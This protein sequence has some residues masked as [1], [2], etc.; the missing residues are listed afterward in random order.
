MPNTLPINLYNPTKVC[1]RSPAVISYYE[2]RILWGQR[3]ILPF[4]KYRARILS[5]STTMASNFL[6]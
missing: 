4:V 2:K 6:S 5:Q 1:E 3:E